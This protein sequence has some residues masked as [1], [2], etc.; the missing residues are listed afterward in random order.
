MYKMKACAEDLKMTLK[1]V[2]TEK[3]DKNT[4]KHACNDVMM[5]WFSEVRN[6]KT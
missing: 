6:I 5:K 1:P 2:D 4:S 3:P